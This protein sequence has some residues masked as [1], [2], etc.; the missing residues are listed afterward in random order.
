M[1]TNSLSNAE[2]AWLLAMAKQG[3]ENDQPGEQRDAARALLGDIASRIQQTEP[4]R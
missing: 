1:T 4:P 3:V 2:T